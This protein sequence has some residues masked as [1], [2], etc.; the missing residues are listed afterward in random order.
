MVIFSHEDNTSVT[1]IEKDTC[2]LKYKKDFYNY[3]RNVYN[4]SRR[5]GWLEEI[6]S[7]MTGYKKLTYGVCS[8]IAS[9]YSSRTDCSF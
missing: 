6:C 1:I 7:H 9:K 3:D 2:L 8:K 5:N 4:A